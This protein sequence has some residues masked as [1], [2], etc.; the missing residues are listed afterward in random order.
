MT[1][2]KVFMEVQEVG[3]YGRRKDQTKMVEAPHV[4][5]VGADG[6]PS[7]NSV[8]FRPN[9]KKLAELA[10]RALN[11]GKV[12]LQNRGDVPTAPHLVGKHAEYVLEQVGYKL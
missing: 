4:A 3:G 2:Y 6:M 7:G 5:L 11:D 12:Q 8:A 10:C 1:R 9:Q